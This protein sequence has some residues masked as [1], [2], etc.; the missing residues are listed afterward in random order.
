[1]VIE[2]LFRQWD[3]EGGEREWRKAMPAIGIRADRSMLDKLFDLFDQAAKVEVRAEEE[4]VRQEEEERARQ[5][6]EE[7]ERLAAERRAEAA[8]HAAVLREAADG[9]LLR[10]RHR[11]PPVRQWESSRKRRSN[12]GNEILPVTRR[13]E[14]TM[15]C[16]RSALLQTTKRWCT[17]IYFVGSVLGFSRWLMRFTARQGSLHP[18]RACRLLFDS[19]QPN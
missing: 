15:L 12:G 1:M 10:T 8:A 3:K 19:S 11:L 5:E 16:R 18:Q 13:L 2:Q 6:A 7:I 9:V 17:T 14:P 4:R